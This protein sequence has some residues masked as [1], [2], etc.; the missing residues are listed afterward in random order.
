MRLYNSLGPNPRVV[1]ML[2]VEKG[3]SIPTVEWDVLTGENRGEAYTSKNPTGQTPALELDDG[4]VIGESVTICEFIDEMYPDVPF[5]G[6]DIVERAIS[7]QW[8]RR[9]ELKIVLYMFD[10][11]RFCEGLHHYEDRVF[12]I[13]GAAESLKAAAREGL[14]WLDGL[15]EGRPFIA[16]EEIRLVDLVLFCCLDYLKDAG[17]PIPEDAGNIQAWFSRMNARPSAAASM[18]PDRAVLGGLCT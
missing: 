6:T 3:V 17:Q 7:R 8:L 10:A 14:L 16:G 15:I 13:P 1:R 2:M 5:V 11:F 4:T 18:H 12:V 9:V